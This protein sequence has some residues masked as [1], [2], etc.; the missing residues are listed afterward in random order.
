MP[1]GLLGAKANTILP[2][3][4]MEL[5]K[6]L[7]FEET[8]SEWMETTRKIDATSIESDTLRWP[9]Y[10]APALPDKKEDGEPAP[11]SG[12]SNYLQDMTF[13]VLSREHDWTKELQADLP[14]FDALVG[15]RAKT[16]GTAYRER[17]F[18]WRTSIMTGSA[19]ETGLPTISTT[20]YDGQAMYSS[21][22]RFRTTGGN[23]ISG[24]GI[25]GPTIRKD[26]FSAVYRLAQFRH[27]LNNAKIWTAPQRLRY[28]VEFSPEHW[29]EFVE[30][31]KVE[32][33][34]T[35]GG[36]TQSADN[37]FLAFAKTEGAAVTI[38]S[39]GYLSGDDW[40]ITVMGQ[41]DRPVILLGE[42]EPAFVTP[43]TEANDGHMA[44]SYKEGVVSHGRYGL[45]PGAVFGTIKVDN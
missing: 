24:T 29:E 8:P 4:Q 43:L 26:F 20:S 6:A 25:S 16:I 45:T 2:K 41:S 31:F 12:M 27:E 5:S 18:Q 33:A 10:T 19:V 17:L 39:N 22:T 36:G 3:I 23:I 40:Y 32:V 30:A 1:G 7:D 21:S 44:R 38:A 13:S 11:I 37:V 15:E 9:I 34:Q 14:N 28:L 35:G 42:K